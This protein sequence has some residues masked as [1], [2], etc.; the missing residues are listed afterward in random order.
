MLN[1][2]TSHPAGVRGLKQQRA[3]LSRPWLASHPAGVRG[4]K[5]LC[6]VYRL[7]GIHVAPRRGA[8]I[9]TYITFF[10]V[11]AP[12]SHPAGVRGLKLIFFLCVV[13][14]ICRTPQGCV[15]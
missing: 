5:R 12:V 15:D 8:W 3:C 4:L 9:E 7:A 1:A 2:L 13:T 10:I 6:Y 14:S 11:R